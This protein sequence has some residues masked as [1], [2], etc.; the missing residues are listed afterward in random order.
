MDRNAFLAG[1]VVLVDVFT[2]ERTNCA[3]VLPKLQRLH[4][5]HSRREFAIVGVHTP[6]IPSYRAER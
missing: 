4:E 3:K 1:R 5:H 6:E 2:F